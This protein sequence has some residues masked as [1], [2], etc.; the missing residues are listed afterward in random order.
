MRFGSLDTTAQPIR[1]YEEIAK[2]AKISQ[3][4]VHYSINNY[5]TRGNH[6]I[7]RRYFNHGGNKHDYYTNSK[8]KAKINNYLSDGAHKLEWV[9]KS[10]EEKRNLLKNLIGYNLDPQAIDSILNKL[11]ANGVKPDNPK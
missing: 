10:P 6:H 1:G 9:Q 5:I 4:T 2:I 11:E 8:I 7:D 3:G